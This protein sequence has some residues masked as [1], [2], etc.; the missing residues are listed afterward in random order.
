M[1]SGASKNVTSR[2][3][4]LFQMICHFAAT[5]ADAFMFLP[6]VTSA[7][8]TAAFYLREA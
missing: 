7:A 1:F 3:S 4:G 6:A 2:G 8:S 5:E